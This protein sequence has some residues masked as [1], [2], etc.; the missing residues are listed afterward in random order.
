MRY[1]LAFLICSSLF[2]VSHV[3]AKQFTSSQRKSMMSVQ[4]R[5]T[6]TLSMIRNK[7]Y[8]YGIGRL[9]NLSKHPQLQNRWT[10]IAYVLGN[11]FF[12]L[13]LYHAAA[14]HYISVVKKGDK[15]YVQRAL[16]KLSE[17][18]AYLGDDQLL[19]FAMNQDNVQKIQ[20][21]YRY[22]LYYLYGRYQLS[23]KNLKRALAYF[24]KVPFRS[25]FYIKARYQ[26]ALMYA[27][28]GDK[29]AA[30]N[31]FNNI[32]T[33]NLSKD[34]VKRVA[35]V[36]GKARVH[37]QFKEWDKAINYYREVPKNS[38]FWHDMLFENS[39]AL[40]RAGKFRSALNGFH[41]LHS[42]YYYDHFQPDS[43]LLRSLIYMYICKYDEMEK[44]LDL[45][46]ITYS[47]IYRWIRSILKIKSKV[48]YYQH[49]LRAVNK[50]DSE[51]S[52]GIFSFP[53]EVAGRIFRQADFKHL[54]HY[55]VRLDEEMQ[56]IKSSS[57]SWR[58]SRVGRYATRIVDKRLKSTRNKID[59]VIE[60]H[61]RVIRA[62]LKKHLDQK[63][64][65]KYEVL[66]GKREYL[67]QKISKKYLGD[68]QVI[69]DKTRDFFVQNGFEFWPFQ[70]EYWLDELGNY[71]YVGTQSCR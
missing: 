29:R 46:E 21:K 60:R 31:A 25:P 17:I 13:K 10:E 47:P 57:R 56:V 64:F 1:I 7:N 18:T 30:I 37:Y 52:I 70:E 14:F 9:Y 68:T 19:N 49:V 6:R 55:M 41:T 34:D 28:G 59:K 8:K 67:R 42:S 69:R 26:M 12:E 16:D 23:K 2:N 45:F 39:W 66:R 53:K 5:L 11:S 24:K 15:R 62:E 40:L 61:L 27:E 36:M 51:I 63:E 44:I 4:I 65:L 20:G 22:T 71:H 38:P 58:A 3:S 50:K 33:K 54:H 43:L 35:A 48:S 32:I